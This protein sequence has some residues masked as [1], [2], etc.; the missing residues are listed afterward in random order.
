MNHH[1]G[2]RI[3]SWFKVRIMEPRPDPDPNDDP[4]LDTNPNRDPNPVPIPEL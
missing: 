2:S 4:N 3:R 1:L